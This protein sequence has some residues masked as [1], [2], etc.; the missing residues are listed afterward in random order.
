[1]GYFSAL[2]T[3]GKFLAPHLT[4]AGLTLTGLAAGGQALS[5]GSRAL[6]QDF[7]ETLGVTPEALAEDENFDPTKGQKGKLTNWDGGDTFRSLFTGVGKQEV[8]A[9][10]RQQFQTEMTDLATNRNEKQKRRATALGLGDSFQPLTYKNKEGEDGFTERLDERKAIL[11]QL[12]TLR[13]LNPEIAKQYNLSSGSAELVNA[14][15]S[16]RHERNK[17]REGSAEW[18]AIKNAGLQQEANTRAN[19]QLQQNAYQFQVQQQQL[20][21][22]ERNRNAQ[23]DADRELRRGEGKDRMELAILDREGQREELR[24][25]RED[26]A[27]ARRRDSMMM[28]IK[29]LS[30]LGAGFAL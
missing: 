24:F 20:A 27:D 17:G 3:A 25:R 12:E 16:A 26:R 10:A 21:A 2:A 19:T 9:A 7:A 28:L 4:R 30:Q 15:D 14:I 23:L 6:N 5:R 11:D 18:T 22:Q 1:M 29:G 8:E 13:A